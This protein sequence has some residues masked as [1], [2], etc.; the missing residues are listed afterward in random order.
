MTLMT[1]SFGNKSAIL[2]WSGK[3]LPSLDDSRRRLFVV[4]VVKSVVG[5]VELRGF[6]CSERLVRLGLQVILLVKV[7]GT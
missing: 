1:N 4:M 2:S 6:C 3:S 7:T 5:Q